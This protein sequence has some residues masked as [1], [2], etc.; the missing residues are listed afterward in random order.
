MIK[1]DLFI[2]NKIDLAPYVGASL[3]VM[4]ADTKTARGNKPFIFTNLKTDTGLDQVMD[5]IK[6][7]VLLAGLE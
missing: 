6:R 3:E 7:N 1:S 4:E 2:I 5:W